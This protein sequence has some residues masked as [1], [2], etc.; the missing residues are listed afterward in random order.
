MT[1]IAKML[2]SLNL[3][4]V[5]K[6]RLKSNCFLLGLE[7]TL[8]HSRGGI[9]STS[10]GYFDIYLPKYFKMISLGLHGRPN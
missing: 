10:L 8:K 2:N 7:S 4:C 3:Q 5:P 1:T 9:F 6:V